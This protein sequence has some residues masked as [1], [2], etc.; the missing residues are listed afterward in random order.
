MSTNQKVPHEALNQ[1]NKY[2]ASATLV[3]LKAVEPA[4]E[5]TG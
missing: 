2:I 3:V 5:S 1:T 4:S